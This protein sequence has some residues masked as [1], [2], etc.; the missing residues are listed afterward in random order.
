MPYVKKN[1]R[2]V[3]RAR[4]KKP[5]NK[6]NKVSSN[7]K[8]YV[9]RVLNRKLENKICSNVSQSLTTIVPMS[10][11]QLNAI[12]L[13]SVWTLTQGTNQGNRIGNLVHPKSWHLKGFFSNGY[14][15]NLPD[16]MIIKMYIFKLKSGFGVP[17]SSVGF[18]QNGNTNLAPQNTF[19]DM[20][21]KVNLDS[22]TLYTTRTFK[23]G[24]QAGT[25]TGS[26]N[27]DFKS[28]CPFSINLLKY[29][30][31]ALKYSDTTSAPNNTGLYMAYTVC[32]ANGTAPIGTSV[33]PAINWEIE[34]T[35][36][37]A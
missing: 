2:M 24:P 37:D 28:V 6:K 7:I 30:K 29:Q 36:E 18:Y 26:G 27:N 32:F 23:C 9:S 5:V 31:S 22:F 20:L 8:A 34:A 16:P 35:F 4:G 25:S 19:S 11:T 14:G 3:R 33:L 12:N 17:G 10:P 21:K 1:K 13:S 15:T